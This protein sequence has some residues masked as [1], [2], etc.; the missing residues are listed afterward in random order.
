MGDWTEFIFLFHVW[1]IY[2]CMNVSGNTLTDK[3]TA[4]VTTICRQLSNRKKWMILQYLQLAKFAT[5]T[6]LIKKLGIS[7]STTSKALASLCGA[8]LITRSKVG[9]SIIYEL[10]DQTWILL[11][12]TFRTMPN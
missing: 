1:N 2:V 8:G 12:D 5:A 9:C 6:V 7:Q 10:N 11:S 4:D 3:A